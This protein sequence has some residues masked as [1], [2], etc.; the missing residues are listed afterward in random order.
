MSIPIY[1]AFS[2]EEAAEA[3]AAS[4]HLACM[5]YQ[6]A[7]DTPALLAPS[8]AP[9]FPC[10][11][12]LQDSTQP[13]YEPTPELVQMIVQYAA[14][15]HTGLLCDVSGKPT[16]FWLQMVSQLDRA[17]EEAKLSMWT[18][19]ACADAAPHSA[20]LVPSPCVSGRYGDHLAQAAARWPGR[21]VLE[22]R[23]LR[24][25]MPLPCPV[26]SEIL[27]SPQDLQAFLH[28]DPGGIYPWEPLRCMYKLVWEDN[29]PSLLLF[30]TPETMAEKIQDAE[31][32]GFAAA[33]GL[34]QEAALFPMA[35][36]PTPAQT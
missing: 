3:A 28:R 6:L 11:L 18:T 27:L 20:V 31:A 32:A 25:R 4:A 15:R 12:L 22:L 13:A 33:V 2:P 7:P 16:E 21:C 26:G 23:P 5:G 9:E 10:M 14:A 17:A 1:L 8:D 36:A 24:C 19:I 29:G 35:P 30:D 34:L